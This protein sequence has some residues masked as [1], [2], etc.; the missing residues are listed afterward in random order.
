MV[1]SKKGLS[2]CLFTAAVLGMLFTGCSKKDSQKAAEAE[3]TETAEA[4]E[5]EGAIT[6]VGPDSGAKMEMWTFVDIHAQFYATMLEK[7][8]A[9][10]PDKQI[11]ITFVNYPYADMHNKMTMAVQ[12]GKGAPDL[13]DIEIG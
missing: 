5:V 9:E 12:T 11:Q 7:W 10:N 3:V 8:N 2:A 13:C 4:A 6:K 1:I